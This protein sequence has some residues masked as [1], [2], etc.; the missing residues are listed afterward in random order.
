MR[1]I[2]TG[3]VG[4]V[5]RSSALPRRP[6]LRGPAVARLIGAAAAAAACLCSGVGA[7]SAS[8]PKPVISAYRSTPATVGSAGYAVLTAT[9]SHATRCT[10]SAP[11]AKPIAGLPVSF[12]CIGGT[13]ER[14]VRL[15]ANGTRKARLYTL[16]LTAFG[17]GISKAVASTVVTVI[18]GPPPPGAT[19]VDAGGQHSQTCG[20]LSNGKLRCWGGNYLGQLGNGTLISS[21]TPVEPVGI[22][23]PVQVSVGW[24]QV[25]ARLSNAHVDC[26]GGNLYGQLGNGSTTGPD[27]CAFAQPPGACSTEPVEVTGVADASSVTAGGDDTCAQLQTGHV[28]CWGLNAF[29]GLGDGS[30]TGPET[31]RGFSCSSVPV[32]VTGLADPIQV[33]AGGDGA[34]ALLPGGHIECWGENIGGEL[35]DGTTIGPERCGPLEIPCSTAPVEV[36]GMTEA[37]QVSSGGTQAC[38]L[39]STSRVDC[40]GGNSYG[41][42]GDGTSERSDVPVEVAGITEA[43]SVSAGG[44][45]TCALLSSGHVDCWGNGESGQLGNGS[46]SRAYTPVETLNIT[47]AVA[48]SAGGDQACALLATGQVDCWGSNYDGQLGNGSTETSYVPV[49]VGL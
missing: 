3:P 20:L 15:P 17:Y 21:D 27:K 16:K 8:I 34:C 29:G 41:Q 22:S 32:E 23:E 14:G 25:C 28:V 24:E 42:L 18:P 19:A 43:T 48:I 39:L 46:K 37:T 2:L 45:F 33:S 49:E 26:W 1:E 6:S 35:G 11:A 13:A 5:S 12:S 38:A 4:G 10:L 40:W 36:T 47:N 30:A 44:D 31:C 9:V 7:A